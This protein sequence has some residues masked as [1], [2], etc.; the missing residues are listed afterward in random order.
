MTAALRVTDGLFFAEAPPPIAHYLIIA[1]DPAR[2]LGM[3]QGLMR[4]QQNPTALDFGKG[5]V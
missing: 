1:P 2:D 4:Q 3:A 5:A